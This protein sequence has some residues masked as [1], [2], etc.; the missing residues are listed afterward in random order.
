MPVPPPPGIDV[1]N[2]EAVNAP[3]DFT[4]RGGFGSVTPGAL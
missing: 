3:R 2:W 4:R 1:E